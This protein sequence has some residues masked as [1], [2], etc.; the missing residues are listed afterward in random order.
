MLAALPVK[1]LNKDFLACLVAFFTF[2]YCMICMSHVSKRWQKS[3]KSFFEQISG[4]KTG[5]APIPPEMQG[6]AVKVN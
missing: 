5:V 2:S 4:R 1:K 6:S 3:Q